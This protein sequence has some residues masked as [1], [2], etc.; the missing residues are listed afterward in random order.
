MATIK[1]TVVKGDT[2]T[3]IAKSYNTTVD[4]LVRLN[5]IKNPNYI[6]VGQ[7]L[8]VSGNA[9]TEKNT[10]SKA[11]VNVFG[12]QTNTDRTMYATWIW[13]KDNTKEYQVYWE[14][15]AGDKDTKKNLV[16]LIG[17]DTTT[18][19]KQSV[20]NAPS[21]AIKVRF[22]VKPISK[23]KTVKGKETTYWTASWSTSKSYSFDSGPPDIPSIPTVTVDKYK[24]TATVDNLDDRAGR[25]QFE[26]IKD[27]KSIYNT[28]I[29]DVTLSHASYSCNLDVGSEY[30]VRCRAINGSQT[31]S[32]WTEY[33]S[34]VTTMP[35]SI[36]G[37]TTCKAN[38]ENSVY[39]EWSSVNTAKTYDI[40][41]ATKKEYFDTSDQTTTK[42]GI[43]LNKYE[44]TNLTMG[45]E[46]FFRVRAV[47]DKGTSAWS[48][49]KSVVIG[50]K[51]I[52]PTT[53]SSTTSVVI[54][55]PLYLYWV[56]NAEDGS[57]QTFAE[58]KLTVNG[59]TNTYTIENDRNEDEKDKTSSYSVDTTQYSDGVK[60]EWSVRTAGVTKEYGD[61]SV[62][63]SIDIYAPLTL[64]LNVT[65]VY[66]ET[67]NELTSFPFYVYGLAGPNTQ[68]PL[69][70]YL[71]VYSNEDYETVDFMGNFKIIKAGD[72]VYTKYFDTNDPLLVEFSAGNIDLE[73][74][75]NYT[76]KCSVTMDSGLTVE[77]TSNFTVA[78]SEDS[79][80]PNAEIAID[81]E[82]LAVYI[83]P[84]CSDENDELLD[85]LLSV[86]RREFDGSFTELITDLDNLSNTF[87]TDPHPALDYARYRIVSKTKDTGAVSYYDIP[88]YPIG[89][90]SVVIQWNE[91]W[92]YFDTIVEDEHSKP[93]WVGSMLKLPYNV[94]VSDKYSTDVQLVEYIGRKHPVS[95]YGTQVGSTATWNVEIDKKDEETLYALRRLAV[96]MG[97]V[98]V[99]EP[100]GSGYWANIQ[101]SFSQTHGTL[102]IPVSLSITRVEGG[103]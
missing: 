49:I 100:S 73:N 50:K 18:T 77:S 101:V 90:K 91:D 93:S 45:N 96:W 82:N 11:T 66:G 17:S 40:E 12:L 5:N 52:A 70:Y 92:S 1:Y 48:D 25:V 33:S 41:Y 19:D 67:M 6:V 75:I 44:V 97:D 30:K 35:S 8:V 72:P 7:V 60:I 36:D 89:E 95:Y 24:L 54:G 15:T 34:N 3:K 46:Y 38:S 76:V 47:N 21:N 27:N 85:V 71:I 103:V 74:N 28:C 20:Y 62:E 16:W 99:R 2:L 79:Y 80:E 32:N 13:T 59:V 58:L 61:W 4:E 84:Y 98:Y 56:H 88:R 26:V 51:P 55:E 31:Y 23:T 29:V 83:R 42:T 87:I 9:V 65:D 10:T 78:W 69:S 94:D 86:Y 68:I 63:R 53:W 22:K 57:S 102:T 14:Y 64:Q 39:L 43:E 37:I 81:E